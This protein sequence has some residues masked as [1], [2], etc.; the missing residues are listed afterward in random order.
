MS[1]VISTPVAVIGAGNLGISVAYYLVK[2]R[3]IR[4][5]VIIDPRDPLCL[6][7]EQ[8]DENYRNW[9]PRPNSFMLRKIRAAGGRVLRG[10]L[11]AVIGANPFDLVVAKSIGVENIK[12]ERV[13]NTAAPMF[14][15]F[16]IDLDAQKLFG[17]DE[18]KD[19][20]AEAQIHKVF[21]IDLLTYPPTGESYAN[22]NN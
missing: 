15:D 7:S 2:N 20:F 10:E 16:T 21:S 4:D 6:A 19:I 11:I 17:T 3:G 5:V 18:E 1:R 9:R 13:V 14:N 12:A 22:L 8:S